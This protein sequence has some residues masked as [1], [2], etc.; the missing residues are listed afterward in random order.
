MSSRYLWLWLVRLLIGLVLFVNIQCA[1]AFLCQ[2]AKYA[3]SFELEGDISETMLR[4]M[5]VLFLMWNV[6]YALAAWH[7]RRH[8]T[9]LLEALA[10]Q[11]IGLLGETALLLLLPPGHE[12]LRAT[13]TRFIVFDGLGLVFL[14]GAVLLGW[15]C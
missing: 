2:P 5:G 1:L 10:M 8:R 7:P 13:A 15:R 6:P 11:A 12:P 9:S 4:G 3:P 14:L